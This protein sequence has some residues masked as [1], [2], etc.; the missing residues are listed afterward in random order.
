[1]ASPF[2]QQSDMGAP[3]ATSQSSRRLSKMNALPSSLF[4]AG[5]PAEIFIVSARTREWAYIKDTDA[6]LPKS[7]YRLTGLKQREDRLNPNECAVR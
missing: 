2:S 3:S 7:Y 5:S 4:R 6:G 1:M